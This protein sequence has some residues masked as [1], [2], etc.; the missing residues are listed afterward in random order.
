MICIKIFKKPEQ[1]SGVGFYLAPAKEEKF[2]ADLKRLP[3]KARVPVVYSAFEDDD[4]N[5]HDFLMMEALPAVSIDDI[6][7]GRAELPANFD[8]VN[9]Q[10]DLMDFVEKMHQKNIYHRDLH[11][12]NIMV[13]K[14]TGQVYVIDFG[15][16]A[17]FFGQPEPGER[18]PYHIT[19]NGRDIILTSDESMVRAVIKKLRTK[20]TVNN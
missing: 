15:A 13:D 4:K 8:L 9:F 7:Q 19:K 2:L 20:L 3:T 5:G 14:E 11:E 10:K 12:G 16:S 1:I 17:R 6:L 18:G